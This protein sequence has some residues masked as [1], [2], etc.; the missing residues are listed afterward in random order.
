MAQLFIPHTVRES[1]LV[2][3]SHSF[4]SG[5]LE[6]VHKSGVLLFSKQGN[7]WS[8]SGLLEISFQ[9]GED[10]VVLAGTF[11]KDCPGIALAEYDHLKEGGT[12]N[13]TTFFFYNP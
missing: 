13:K 4:S 12:P 10:K 11:F 3:A 6:G 1:L 9:E 7:Q 2:A 5:F 8:L